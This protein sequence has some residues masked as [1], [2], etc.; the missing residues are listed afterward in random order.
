MYSEKK[1]VDV[2]ISIL[3]ICY[4]QEQYISEALDSALNQTQL[5][6]E[7]VISDD[8]STDKTWPLILKYQSEYPKLIKAYRNDVNIGIYRNYEKIKNYYS[9][10]IGCFLSGDDLIATS[11]IQDLHHGIIEHQLNPDKEKFIFVTNN[12]LLYPN[13][14][15]KKWDNYKLRD[16]D[17]FKCK[18]RGDL[19]YRGFGISKGVL[20]ST[21]STVDMVR[22]F[23]DILYGVDTIKGIEEIIECDRLIFSNKY[24]VFYRTGVGVSSRQGEHEHVYLA[25]LNLH[26]VLINRYAGMLDKSDINYL[27]FLKVSNVYRYSPSLK[28][29]VSVIYHYIRNINNFSYNNGSFNNLKN[30]IPPS[31]AKFIKKN[32]YPF[33]MRL[34]S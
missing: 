6:Y 3:M 9:G 23:Q 2:K 14:S 19:S 8:C 15:L 31:I 28:N 33:V 34:K 11:A 21:M 27:E 18:I 25:A 12:Y 10:N 29:F 17:P 1:A 5:P 4:N 16:D 7:I 32:I 30:I 13:G 26:D 22:E 24:S 20:D